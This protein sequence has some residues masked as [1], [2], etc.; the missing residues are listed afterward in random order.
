MSNSKLTEKLKSYYAYAYLALKD[1]DYIN[2]IRG[3]KFLIKN[4]IEVEKSVIGLICAYSC[5]GKYSKALEVFARNHHLL[6]L[7]KNFRHM[8]IHDLSFLLVNDTTALKK[9]RDSYFS[10]FFLGRS[11]KNT[12]DDYN[13]NNTNILAMI[14]LSYWYF[15]TGRRPN[16]ANTILATCLHFPTLDKDFRWK[17]LRRLSITNNNL[18]SDTLIASKFQSIPKNIDSPDYLNQLILSSLYSNNLI[19]AQERITNAKALEHL[20]SNEVMWNY[21]RLS[22]DKNG[23]DETCVFFAQTLLQDGWIDSYVA[24]AIKYGITHN[25]SYSVENDL[26]KLQLLGY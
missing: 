16:G 19:Q 26:S 22:I 21:I 5:L 17:L 14:L 12:M 23:I 13:N 15:I 7:N 4:K 25:F 2:A 24:K 18:L 3:F 20:F 10:S 11:I 1:K 9:R 8:L 6:V